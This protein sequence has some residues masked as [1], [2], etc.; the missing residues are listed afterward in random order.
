MKKFLYFF[1]YL[2]IYTCFFF[3]IHAQELTLSIKAEKPISQG[4]KDS[5]LMQKSFKDF[6]T[7]KKGAD[8]LH[9]KLQ[10]MGFIESELLQL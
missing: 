1:I 5:L 7:L 6:A 8:T 9:L 10:R 4:V 2:N 3:G